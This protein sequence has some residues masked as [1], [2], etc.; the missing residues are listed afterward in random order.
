VDDGSGY[1]NRAAFAPPP[2]G[3]YGN[4][5]RNTIPGPGRY[6][7]NLSLSRSFHLSEQQRLE[8]RLDGANLTNT[9]IFTN[10][11][12]VLNALN[13]GNPTAAQA[14][15]AFRATLRYKF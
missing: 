12:T 9:P 3:R 7:V 2:F 13:Y 5:G 14:M 8:F 15:R 10:F 4:A 11:G 6:S 1:F